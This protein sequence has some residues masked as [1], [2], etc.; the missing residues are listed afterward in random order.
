[1]N[2]AAQLAALAS[3]SLAAAAD[4]DARAASLAWWADQPD[5]VREV[6][7][8]R[9]GEW[10]LRVRPLAPWELDGKP[11]PERPAG[12]RLRGSQDYEGLHLGRGTK[13]IRP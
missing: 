10:T 7:V 2:V 9:A 4:R 8:C 11:R 6:W 12:R 5:D 1:M 13:W 3:A